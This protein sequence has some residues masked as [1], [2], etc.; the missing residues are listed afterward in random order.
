MLIKT[1]VVIVNVKA[2]II[3]T[4]IGILQHLI[5]LEVAS[6]AIHHVKLAM[7][8]LFKIVKLVPMD[9]QCKVIIFVNL[10]V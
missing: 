2:D 3:F 4:L 6:N 7:D 8:H 9:I 1:V 5:Y 10:I